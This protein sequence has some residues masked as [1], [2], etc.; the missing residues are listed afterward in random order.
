MTYPTLK[1][2]IDGEWL[3]AGKR[4]T[5]KVINPATGDT[6]GE[7]PLADAADLDQALAAADKGFRVWRKASAEER[8]A[9]LAGAAR[10]LRERADTI[11]RNAT[12][13]EGKTLAETKMELM[14]C[15]GL[16]EFY[17]AEA[18]RLYGR[19]LVRP[20][21]MRSLVVREPVGPVA[22]F[23]PW[24]F[25]IHNPGRKLGAPLA[26]GCSVILKP[27]EEAP[28]SAMAVVQALLDA[29]L[30]PGVCQLVFGVP[31]E[32][33]RHLLASPII[34]KLSF[35]GS[36]VVG[37][38]LLKLAADTMKRTTMELGG[39]A[40]VIV[41]DDC[42]LEKTVETLALAKLR[43]AGQVCVSPT[44]FYV[45]EGVHD[46]FVKAYSER[47]ARAKVGDGLQE[48][49]NMGPMAN[50]RRPDAIEGFIADAVKHG[51]K[52]RTGGERIGNK[53][54]FFQPTVITDA[55][56]TA[57]IMNEEPFGPV[58]ATAPFKTFDEVVEQANRLPFG[59]AGYAFTENG[60][61]ANLISDALEVGMVGLN[62]TAM[63]APDSPFGG[64]KE[65]GHGS[66][67]GPEGLDACLV[68]K[69]I[70][71]V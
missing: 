43:N 57:R 62:T 69:S 19:V 47:V 5:H 66:E 64:V 39:H 23:A 25:P 6:L 44:R 27:A 15:A 34:R 40:P 35:T 41:F 53:G 7:L 46:R 14:G 70:H 32:V 38:H 51:A 16:F 48:G 9:V 60:R 33:S 12:L 10:L 63:A 29:G 55:P 22:A 3:S 56:S 2:H 1:L 65:S 13:E 59:L 31:D 52:V 45:Q 24:N 61:T 18:K 50:P 17:A 11:A 54:Y 30:P 42:N 21:G 8:G 26:T 67:D 37:K 36:T 68:T 28:A 20:A 71:Q 4:R 58:V 49:V